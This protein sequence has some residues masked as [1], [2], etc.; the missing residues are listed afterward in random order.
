M[1]TG[2]SY[3]ERTARPA[4]G[5]VSVDTAR[6]EEVAREELACLW[7]D[8][9]TARQSA[10]NGTWSI[11][12]D[13]LTE[14]IKDLTKVIGPTPWDEIQINLL[15]LGIYQRIHAELGIDVP[16]VQ[17]DMRKIA[18]LRARLDAQAAAIRAGR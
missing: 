10:I 15:E 3:D 4:G 12:C 8:L 17:P 6:L 7:G 18:E 14:R 13:G 2:G 9:E 1:V 5:H 11:R 16:Q